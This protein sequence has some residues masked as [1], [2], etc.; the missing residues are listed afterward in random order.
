MKLDID[1]SVRIL[2]LTTI[3]VRE[4]FNTCLRTII[5]LDEFEV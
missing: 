3:K 4:C 1:T 5:R 2:S